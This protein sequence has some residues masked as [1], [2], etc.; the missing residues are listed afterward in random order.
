MRPF[1]RFALVAALLVPLAA[2]RLVQAQDATASRLTDLRLASAVRLAIATDARTRG[3]DVDVIARAG[4]VTLG[5]SLAAAD[6]RTASDVARAVRGVAAVAGDGPS[7]TGTTAASTVT[8]PAPAA[9]PAAE[10]YGRAPAP[11]RPALREGGDVAYHTVARGETLFSLARTYGT[12]VDAV[13]RLNGLPG[14]DIQI[15]QRLRMR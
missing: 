9:P 14:P 5:G 15:G 4:V 10:P 7:P 12:T 2:P 3:L 6:R 1:S 13:V 8:A 11:E